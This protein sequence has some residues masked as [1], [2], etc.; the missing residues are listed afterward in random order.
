MAQH[1]PSPDERGSAGTGPPLVLSDVRR[2]HRR[3]GRWVLDGVGLAVDPGTAVQVVGANGCGKTTLLRVAGGLLPAQGG[4][5]HRRGRFAFVPEKPPP[6]PPMTVR[7]LLS[8]LARVQGLPIGAVGDRVDRILVDHHLLPVSARSAPELSKGWQQRC[9]LA[10]AMM[11]MPDLLLLD[12]PWT[13]LDR[14]SRSLFVQLLEAH[15]RRGGAVLIASHEPVGLTGVRRVR[16]DSGS[17]EPLTSEADQVHGHEVDRPTRAPAADGGGSDA[18]RVVLAP[19]GGGSGSTGRTVA[20]D[21][22]LAAHPA[23]TAVGGAGADARRD[24]G[25]DSGSGVGTDRHGEIEVLV[26]GEGGDDFIAAA[27]AAGWSVRRV[28]PCEPGS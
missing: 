18:R 16:L 14:E 2:R 21:S 26:G 1:P 20:L 13:G 5:V 22:E 12:E 28:E 4:V 6:L 19:E 8:H 11:A 25:S 24:A 7:R 15:R 10:Q 27:I 23:V 9:V 17:L 3:R